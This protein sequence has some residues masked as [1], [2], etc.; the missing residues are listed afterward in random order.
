MFLA[1]AVQNGL[2]N[3]PA[4]PGLEKP[5]AQEAVVAVLEV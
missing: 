5:A 1:W 2:E 4:L 3:Q